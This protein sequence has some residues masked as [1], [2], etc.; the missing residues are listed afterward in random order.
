MRSEL[1]TKVRSQRQLERAWRLVE[2]NG[3]FSTSETVRS[4]IAAYAQEFQANI[5]SLNRRLQRGTYQF[6]PSRGVAIPKTKSNGQKDR[7]KIRPLVVGTVESRIVQRSILEVLS[8]VP[9]LRPH[10]MN[11]NS[12]GGIR[13][14]SDSELSAVPAAIFAVL[15]S[16]ERGAEFV[17]CADITGFFTKIPKPLVLEIIGSAIDDLAMLSFIEDAIQVELTN[18][19]ALRRYA[20]DFPT[21]E[22]GVAQGNSLSPLL[23]NILLSEFDRVMNDGDCRCIRYIDDFIILAPTAS[24]AAARLRH[25]RRIL[26]DLGME[27]SADK[28][29][30]NPINVRDTFEFL[31]IEFSNGLIRPCAKARRRLTESLSETFQKSSHSLATASVENPIEKRYSLIKTLGRSD[32]MLQGWRKH[33]WFCNDDTCFKNLDDK[34]DAL[35]SAYLGSYAD[36]RRRN[37]SSSLRREMLGL[38]ALVDSVRE[39][40]AWPKRAESPAARREL[41]EH[42]AQVPPSDVEDDAPPWA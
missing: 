25:A 21:G 1:L 3:R 13:K 4:E 16:I 2:A 15:Q 14:T 36:A 33:Y 23:G 41:P 18:L 8:G 9:L 30:S 37:E 10:F 17:M 32:G 12:F 40:F 42:T 29:S 7:A 6:P 22:I 20:A 35:I 39:P 28:T 26:S 31:G 27:L 11:P 24:A 5:R 34:V 19:A 38:H